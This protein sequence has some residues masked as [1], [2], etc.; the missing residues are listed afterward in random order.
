[1][2]AFAEE[3]TE[4]LRSA[5][6]EESA[7]PLPVFREVFMNAPAAMWLVDDE[8]RYREVNDA[9]C[10]MLG[11]AREKLLGTQVDEYADD[12]DRRAIPRLW[13]EFVRA[14][15]SHGELHFRSAEGDVITTR[16]V[17]QAD[18]VPGLHLGIFRET[19]RHRASVR[20]AA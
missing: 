8:R 12:Q 5:S 19:V 6:G 16:F 7:T 4:W 2:Y 11:V 9:A 14:R 3:L 10:E 17:A 20:P 13:D 15:S 18:V 1:V